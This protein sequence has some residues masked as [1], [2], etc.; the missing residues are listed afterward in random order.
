MVRPSVMRL[1]SS[2]HCVSVRSRDH[3]R[4]RNVFDSVSGSD[5]GRIYP[6][7]GGALIRSV[8]RKGSGVGG[9]GGVAA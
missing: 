1:I 9:G 6:V 5:S 2:D 3:H 4:R 7:A 8:Q